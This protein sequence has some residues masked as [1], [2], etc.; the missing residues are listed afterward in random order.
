MMLIL[1]DR[2][3]L[4]DAFRSGGQLEPS[5]LSTNHSG[6][7][8]N[9]LFTD[10]S[11]NWLERSTINRD[12]KIWMPHEGLKDGASTDDARDVFLAH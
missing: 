9:G 4:I 5:A 2:N 6:R 11:I 3:P 12:D 10:G 8:Q 1:A 7:G